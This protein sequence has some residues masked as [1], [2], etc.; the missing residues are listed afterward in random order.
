MRI[1]WLLEYLQVPYKLNTFPRDQTSK[2]AE[3]EPF[4]GKGLAAIHPIGRSPLL[5]DDD[6]QLAESGTIIRYLLEYYNEK[7]KSPKPSERTQKA[8]DMNFWI[9]FS[10]ASIMLHLIPLNYLLKGKAQ[11]KDGSSA[12]EKAIARGIRNDMTFVE[13]SLEK[14][15]GTLAGGSE[16]GPAD[17]STTARRD[18]GREEREREGQCTDSLL[19]S[20]PTCS[21]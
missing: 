13:T 3:C 2:L 14:N 9:D 1:L 11:T 17:V 16:L 18:R 7:K 12:Q 20:L 21:G 4:S 10:E 6:L 8:L 19:P 15:G 5:E